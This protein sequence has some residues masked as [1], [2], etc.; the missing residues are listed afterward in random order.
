MRS[1]VV[2]AIALSLSPLSAFADVSVVRYVKSGGYVGMGA[3]EGTESSWVSAP[4]K[5]KQESSVKFT[6]AVL[7]MFS[8]DG[9]KVSLVRVDQDR[10]CEIVA[11]DKKYECRPIKLPEEQKEQYRQAM[12]GEKGKPAPAEK[13]G[14]PTVKVVKNEFTVKKTGQSK[15]INGFP[16]V[17]YSARWVMVTEDLQTGERNAYRMA[18]DF[19]NTEQTAALKAMMAEE[20]SF[21][22]AYFKKMGLDMPTAT[23]QQLG[24]NVV[25]SMIGGNAAK[26]KK[27]MGKMGGVSIVS[28]VKW[29]S[30][31]EAAAT[32]GKPAAKE[33]S[34]SMPDADGGWEGAL[35]SLAGSMA[36]SMMSG[37]Q[38]EEKLLFDGYTEIKSVTAAPLP[39]DT[40]EIPAGYKE[41][42][43]M[44]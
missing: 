3:S 21:A 22:K 2:L 40:F 5:R 25:G 33:D 36:E 15:A 42:K 11:S 30:Q 8:G 19:W 24:L 32:K 29:T 41:N 6:G 7:G 43:G 16:C 28:A 4:N 35:G 18:G 31:Q 23:D 37:K 14:K 39:A 38:G 17:E 26:F 1:L 27:E 13:E 10:Q 20:A 9:A 12:G 34:S 44:F